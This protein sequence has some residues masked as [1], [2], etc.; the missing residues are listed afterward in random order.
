MTVPY[1]DDVVGPGLDPGPDD[2][3]NRSLLAESLGL[4]LVPHDQSREY[5]A[6]FDAWVE[7]DDDARDRQVLHRAVLASLEHDRLAIACRQAEADRHDAALAVAA[8]ARKAALD[9]AEARFASDPLEGAAALATCGGGLMAL[10]DC[11]HQ[12]ADF[13]RS[14][15]PDQGVTAAFLGQ[16]AAQLGPRP[17]PADL[18]VIRAC[19]PGPAEDL[20]AARAP[21]ALCECQAQAHRL[22]AATRLRAEHQ[23][24]GRRA[25]M[26][27]ATPDAEDRLR[28]RRMGE[29]AREQERAFAALNRERDRRRR[30]LERQMVRAGKEGGVAAMLQSFGAMQEGPAMR[31]Q[32]DEFDA[33]A[34]AAEAAEAAGPA[35]EPGALGD[36]LVRAVLSRVLGGA[37]AASL[38]PAGPGPVGDPP[39]ARADA[40]DQRETVVPVAP[41]APRDDSLRPAEVGPIGETPKMRAIDGAPAAKVDT[42]PDLTA[43]LRRVQEAEER[44]R[45]LGIAPAP[46]RSGEDESVTYRP[47]PFKIWEEKQRRERERGPSL[48]SEDPGPSREPEK[49]SRADAEAPSEGA[50][51]APAPTVSRPGPGAAELEPTYAL[52]LKLWEERKRR[53][54]AASLGQAQVGPPGGPEEGNAGRVG[55]G[56]VDLSGSSQAGA[57]AGPS[58]ASDVP[59]HHPGMASVRPAPVGPSGGPDNDRAAGAPRDAPGSPGSA[60]WGWPPPPSPG[61]WTMNASPSAGGG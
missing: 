50:G 9:V 7:Q 40:A 41:A 47:S 17:D 25:L 29:L 16:L 30:A 1:D 56:G 59:E 11:W 34:A 10:A 53:E 22:A 24:D 8:E 58:S 48:R 2:L 21:A 33:R 49:T 42:M 43:Y 60:P 39:E 46:S 45:A 4:D 54:Q 57:P 38:G 61:D 14:I 19:A 36:A 12:A 26:R 20:A 31:R 37:D 55:P 35:V 27:A 5:R 13:A 23:E 32:Y 51:V 44:D 6:R 18:A 15:G 52:A 3:A 28:Q